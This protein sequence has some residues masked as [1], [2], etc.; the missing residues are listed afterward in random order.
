MA[1]LVLVRPIGTLHVNARPYESAD[2]ASLIE[3]YTASIRELAAPYYSSEQIAAWAPVAPDPGRWEERLAAL[4]TVVAESDGVLAGFASYTHDG[5]LDF[6]FTHPNYARRGVASLLYQT[7]E[8]ALRLLGIARITTHA[9]LAARPFFEQQ[10]FAVD[11][12]ECVECR[13]VLLRRLAMHKLLRDGERPNQ[14]MQPTP[15]RR[16]AYVFR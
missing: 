1:D 12:E 15:T 11:A 14:A 2:L 9:S 6:L 16:T 5:Y 4:Y 8:S 3:T 10:A 7:V 13:G